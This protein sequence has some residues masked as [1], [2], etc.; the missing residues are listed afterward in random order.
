MLDRMMRC[1]LLLSLLLL[2]PAAAH[3]QPVLASAD[4]REAIDLDGPWNW[5]VDPYRDGLSGFHGGEAA[6][7]HRRY[8]DVDTT[9]A[10][11]ADPKALY[12]YDM[13]RSPVVHLPRLVPAP[14][15][16]PSGARPARLS[17]LRRGRLPRLCL[18]QRQV[19]RGASGRV[20]S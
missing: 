15:H 16:R 10:M 8:D 9:A 7:G 18:R 17:A 19:R 5:S 6:P 14:L 3:A 12:E 2:A 1:L 4:M 11:R 20:H 13:D